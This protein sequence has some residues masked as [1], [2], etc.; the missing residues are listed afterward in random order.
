MSWQEINPD[1]NRP[2]TLRDRIL[3][4]PQIDEACSRAFITLNRDPTDSDE[5]KRLREL[6]SYTP[7]K[8]KGLEKLKQKYLTAS[9]YTQLERTS[10]LREFLIKA[11]MAAVPVGAVALLYS[12]F[13]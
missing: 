13:R 5:L 10:R 6:P 8:Y 11:N 4:K 2:W 7:D 3:L 9:G 1:T 12:L